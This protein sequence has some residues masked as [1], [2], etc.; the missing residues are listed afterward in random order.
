MKLEPW[1]EEVDG[2]A[3]LDAIV[4]VAREYLVLPPGGAE[5]IA[6]WSLFAHAHDAFNI[7]PILGV[8]SPT[9]ECG[10]T[11]FLILLEFL[12]PSPLQ[13]SNVTPAPLFRAIEKWHPTL[14][15]DEMDTF[16][17]TQEELRGIL[18]SGHNRR[19][20]HVLR[21]EGESFEV[22]KFSTWCPK[23]LAKI[24]KFPPT[25]YSRSIRIEL[26]RKPPGVEVKHLREDRPARLVDLARQ[27]VRWAQD[28]MRALKA[29]DPEMPEALFS[30]SA[31]NWRPLLAVA[32]LAGADWPARARRVAAASCAKAKDETAAIVLLEDLRALFEAR[33]A[34]RLH[35]DD[36]VVA[37][38]E[39]DDRPWSEWGK[40]RRPISKHQLCEMLKPFGLQA[41][42]LRIGAENK[43]GYELE[44]LNPVFERYLSPDTPSQVSTSLQPLP[45]KA[46]RGIQVPTKNEAVEGQKAR[47]PLQANECREVESQQGGNGEISP[48]YPELP[49]FLDR[50]RP[51]DG[52]PF[53]S[54]KD[55]KWG[56]K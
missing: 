22:R 10:K 32:D 21:C 45:A 37:L 30:R 9:H 40:A 50:R 20:A 29:A 24:G 53:A 6:L 47:K 12:V 54:T 52:D 2:G 4:R 49:E 34:D 28:N 35:S 36:I 7:S 14:L 19:A 17:G 42:Q 18:N 56:M 25:L 48:D 46:L 13:T 3:L 27:C 51:A 23:I 33:A 5:A 26:Q 11:T 1:P 44:T 31:D 43:N 8:S 39:L 41:K 38:H 15:V 16:L 55:E